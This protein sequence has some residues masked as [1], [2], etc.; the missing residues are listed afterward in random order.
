MISNLEISEFGE[1]VDDDS[2]NDVESDRGDEDEEREMEE[3]EES[4][5]TEGVFRRVTDQLLH[6]QNKTST[7]GQQQHLKEVLQLISVAK[8]QL[9]QHVS[10]RENEPSEKAQPAK[11]TG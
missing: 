5:T 9:T 1:G 4:E 2:K 10:P 11:V 3:N 6:S 7:T 8:L